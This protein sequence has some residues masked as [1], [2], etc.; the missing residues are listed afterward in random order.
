MSISS[1]IFYDPS[2]PS[3]TRLSSVSEGLLLQQGNVVNANEL[4]KALR[5][6]EGGTFVNMHAPYFPKEA[7]SDILAFLKRGGG[8]VSI[9][10]APFKRPVLR[11]E[12]GAWEAEGQQTAYHRELHIHEILPVIAAPIEKLSA[13]S[14]IPLLQGKEA[15]FEVSGTWNLVPHV[16]KTSDLPHQM[17]SA[18]PMDAQLYPLLKGVSSEGREVAAP[19]VLWENMNGKFGGCALVIR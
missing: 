12:A 16:T 10:G 11:N 18:G 17:G 6:A 8:L 3:D 7:W 15:M 4:S 1:V 9:G 14:D 19:I 5:A 2:F 13:H